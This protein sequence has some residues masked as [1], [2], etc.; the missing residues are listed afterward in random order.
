MP[1]RKHRPVFILLLLLLIQV[2]VLSQKTKLLDS[3]KTRAETETNDSLKATLFNE[4]AWQYKFQDLKES[5]KYCLQTIELATKAGQIKIRSSAYNTLGLVKTESNLFEEGI[6]LMELSL[7]DKEKIGDKKGMATVK[8]NIGVAYKNMGKP[9]LARQYYAEALAAHIELGNERGQADTY[10][11]LGVICRDQG[12]LEK[13]DEYFSL[14]LDLHQKTGNKN[15][16]AIVYNNLF[17]NAS[18]R[19]EYTRGLDY[20][21]KA[22]VIFESINNR[23]ALV[24]VYGNIAKVNKELYKYKEALDY[25]QK[26]IDLGT[27]IGAHQ[28]IVSVYASMGDIYF[29]KEQY[30]KALQYYKKGLTYGIKNAVGKYESHLYLGQGCCYLEEKDYDKALP[31][32]NKA[33]KISRDKQEEKPL[34]RALQ[35]L[36][37]YYVETNEAGKAKKPLDE[38]IRICRTN[39]YK[40][41]LRLCYHT[42]AN[43]EEKTGTNNQAGQYLREASK[44]KD[45]IF[46]NDL[47]QQFAEMQT[48]YETGKKEAEIKLLKQQEQIDNLKIKEQEASLQKQ[49][50]L[51]LFF[52]IG[53]VLLAIAGYFYMTNMRLKARLK[54]EAAIKATEE[55]ERLRMA[56]DIH[57][58]LGSGLSKISFLSELVVQQKNLDEEA[59]ENLASISET[60]KKLVVN[61]RDLIWALNP[62]NTTLSGLVARLREYSA[63]YLEDYTA[64]LQLHFPHEVPGFG[65]TKESHRQVLMVLKESLNNIVK[66][67]KATQ[68]E[69]KVEINHDNFTLVIRDNGVG[70]NVTQKPGNG[71]GNMRSRMT[72]IGGVFKLESQREKGTCITVHIPL[73]QMQNHTLVVNEE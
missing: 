68:V 62:D 65:I 12:L 63:D 2:P 20:L 4:L 49:R 54:E 53:L 26:A 58:D 30:K 16:Q 48:R 71:L 45:T 19:A 57:D 17:A 29:M 64:G 73:E 5:E 70:I 33:I 39:D 22:A 32:I 35:K 72:T 31:A 11:N 37:K 23:A 41:I 18:D 55:K 28:N 1:A 21:Y 47:A 24:S 7:A 42:Y 25:C 61:M 40:D 66:H 14:A 6:K 15:G 56:K 69:V 46:T 59:K 8:N 9:E 44:L 60:S 52:V 34:A 10:S 50:Y 36:A 51:I 13:S 3:L 27:A 38:S 67:S 43:L